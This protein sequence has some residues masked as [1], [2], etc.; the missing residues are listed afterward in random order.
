MTETPN[1]LWARSEDAHHESGTP[2]SPM[3]EERV[4]ERRRREARPR[5]N[6]QA[7]RE[8]HGHPGPSSYRRTG[9]SCRI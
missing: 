4:R 1:R 8:G 6:A 5:T 3:P 9:E 2:H 7:R